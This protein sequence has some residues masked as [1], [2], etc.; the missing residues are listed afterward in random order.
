MDL[1]SY[2]GHEERERERER[3]RRPGRKGGKHES[4]SERT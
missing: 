2:K 4:T 3:E 1:V